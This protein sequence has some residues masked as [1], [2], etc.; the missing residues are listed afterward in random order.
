MILYTK[1]DQE[2]EIVRLPLFRFKWSL[3]EINSFLNQ[4]MLIQQFLSKN[5][6]KKTSVNKPENVVQHEAICIMYHMNL[7][8]PCIPI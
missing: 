4:L 2:V 5:I 6:L 7:V 3:L 8:Y 1:L